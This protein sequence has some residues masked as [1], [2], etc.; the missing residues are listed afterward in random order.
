MGECIKVARE[1]NE[2]RRDYA[3]EQTIEKYTQRLNELM[4][5]EIT[6]KGIN[7]NI[8]MQMMTTKIG[9]DYKTLPAFKFA[10]ETT[11]VPITQI[12]DMQSLAYALNIV[13]HAAEPAQQS[14]IICR[15]LMQYV[16][17]IINIVQN[18][19]EKLTL[20]NQ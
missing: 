4:T 6:C 3:D 11:Y 20:T 7:Q 14:V 5:C 8:P 12:L 1:G 13:D 16:I 9:V 19:E 2:A 18:S 10:D 17:K 15:Q